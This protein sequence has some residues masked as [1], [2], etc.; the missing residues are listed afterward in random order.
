MTDK[1]LNVLIKSILNTDF[2]FSVAKTENLGL[3]I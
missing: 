2:T 3:N 1:M